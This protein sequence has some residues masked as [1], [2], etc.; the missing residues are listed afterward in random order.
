MS[1][2][3][4][5]CGAPEAVLYAY[6]PAVLCDECVQQRVAERKAATAETEASSPAETEEQRVRREARRRYR[7]GKAKRQRK[8]RRLQRR[9][10]AKV[11]FA[12]MQRTLPAQ[13]AL[14]RVHIHAGNDD[15][16]LVMAKAL[17]LAFIR[18]GYASLT[19]VMVFVW[20]T[21]RMTSRMRTGELIDSAALTAIGA[22]LSSPQDSPASA[23]LF[24]NAVEVLAFGAESESGKARQSRRRRILGEGQR[25]AE[26]CDITPVE[27]TEVAGG[28]Q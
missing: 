4:E 10:D 13:V 25:L 17:L 24:L 26:A 12:V 3:C 28:A 20:P 27:L 1:K 7:V 11:A 8:E 15:A 22:A 9:D 23:G 6:Y 14:V 21:D 2:I 19:G 16:A 18:T 5:A